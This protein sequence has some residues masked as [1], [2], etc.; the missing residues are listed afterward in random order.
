LLLPTNEQQLIGQQQP[1]P[2]ITARQNVTP[3]NLQGIF[4][5]NQ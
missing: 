5:Q 2:M 1:Q 3:P 4:S